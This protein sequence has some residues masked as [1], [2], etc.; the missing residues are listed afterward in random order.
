MPK[1]EKQQWLYKKGNEPKLYKG[2]GIDDAMDDGW[3][4]TPAGIVEDVVET[5]ATIDTQEV[6]QEVPLASNDNV[7]YK[8]ATLLQVVGVFKNGDVFVQNEGDS[9][10]QW[11]IPQDT[12]VSTYTPFVNPVLAHSENFVE[13]KELFP[14]ELQTT[15]P[16]PHEVETDEED[17]QAYND[18]ELI[19]LTTLSDKDLRELGKKEGIRS[20][21]N[22]QRERLIDKIMAKN[23]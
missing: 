9:S 21:H 1:K 13:Q 10:D 6:E 16:T 11:R 20:Y 18:E 19:D 4:D 8:K 23:A 15:E 22:M 3:L 7:L 17:T 5:D 12:F 14:A 2:D